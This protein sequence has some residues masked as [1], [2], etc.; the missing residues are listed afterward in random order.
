MTITKY[1]KGWKS[2]HN[3]PL[4]SRYIFMRVKTFFIFKHE[5]VGNNDEVGMQSQYKNAHQNKD[6]DF[7]QY[8]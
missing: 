7:L 5:L 8:I 3:D 2:T 1:C 4:A 6:I